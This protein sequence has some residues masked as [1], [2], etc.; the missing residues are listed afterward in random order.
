MNNIIPIA[1]GVGATVFLLERSHRYHNKYQNYLDNQ[2]FAN[3]IPITAKDFEE[4]VKKLSSEDIYIQLEMYARN[5]P[6]T[7]SYESVFGGKS[8]K[9]MHPYTRAIR[10]VDCM[11]AGMPYGDMPEVFRCHALK[12]ELEKRGVD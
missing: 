11:D 12:N 6:G 5:G 3:V 9:A 7:A 10:F 2:K 4:E 1:C 8:V